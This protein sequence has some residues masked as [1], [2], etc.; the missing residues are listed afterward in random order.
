MTGYR[1]RPDQTAE[2]LD[3]LRKQFKKAFKVI[4]PVALVTTLMLVF[5]EGMVRV[6]AFL[7]S[8]YGAY[9]FSYGF[10]NLN[11]KLGIS[12]WSTHTGGYY[13][14][15]PNYQLRGAAGQAEEVAS[16]NSLGF[17]GPEFHPGKPKGTFRI[18]CLGGSSTFGYRNSDGGTYPV[19]L[20]KIL[21][22]TSGDAGIEVINAGFPYYNSASVFALLREEVSRYDPDL[23]TLYSAFNDAAWPLKVNFFARALFWIQ[24]HSAIYLVVKEIFHMDSLYFKLV[25]KVARVTRPNSV[26]YEPFKIEID[27]VA[28]RFRKNV[29]MIVKFAK[30]KGIAVVLIKQPMTAQDRQSDSPI[31]YEG[32]Y[33]AVMEKFRAGAFLLPNQLLLIKHHRLIEELEKIAKEDGVDV[34]DNIA[35]VDRSGG[36][37]ASWVHLTE[38]ANRRLAEALKSAIE[39]YIKKRRA[40]ARQESAG[41][42]H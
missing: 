8:D 6:S 3:Q 12:P 41:V 32:E 35:I 9:Y 14:F 22:Q 5:A 15:P 34:V 29:E 38:E 18:F 16:I 7:W 19:Q 33:Q 27:Q 37:L 2:A 40:P 42:S 26:D 1:N 28:L 23:I 30:E 21:R 10:R 4:V 31:S 17:R 11:G 24:E 20:E 39:P 13:K 36:G 25:S